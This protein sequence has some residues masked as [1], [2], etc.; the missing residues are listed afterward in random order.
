MRMAFCIAAAALAAC[1]SPP[2]P[3]AGGCWVDAY[4]EPQYRG[5][6]TS[7]TGPTHERVFMKGAASLVVGPGARL[8]GYD[9][10]GFSKESLLLRQGARVPDL[11][12]LAFHRRVESFRLVCVD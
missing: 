4:A 5:T 12:R 6:M 7:Y 2:R 1:T 10:H 11:R 3:L 8:E 9:D